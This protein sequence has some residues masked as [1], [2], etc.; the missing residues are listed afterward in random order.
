MLCY[1]L[2]AM[3]KYFI[4]LQGTSTYKIVGTCKKMR[5]ET[6]TNFKNEE[7][8]KRYCDSFKVLSQI[9]GRWKLL[10]L[11]YLQ[12]QDRSYTDFKGMLPN[13]SDRILTKQLNE[14]TADGLVTKEKTKTSS[15]YSLSGYGKSFTG[16]L[17]SLQ[18]VGLYEAAYPSATAP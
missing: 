9:S 12:E 4:P 18:E 15:V 5:K 1:G 16:V 7:T 6:S 2:N 10:I 13:V 3:Q 11:F 14:L 17:T 8:L